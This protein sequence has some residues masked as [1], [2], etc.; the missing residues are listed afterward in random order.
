MDPHQVLGVPPG[1]GRESIDAA[2]Q[3]AIAKLG[4][5]ED[6]WVR[7]AIDA[8]YGE[9][10]DEPI[11]RVARPTSL[12]FFHRQLPLQNETTY[13]ILVNVL[14]LFMT[15]L[16]LAVQG[17]EANPIAAFFLDRWGFP[18]MIAYKMVIVAVVCTISQVVAQR[19]MR[20][21]RGLLW[22]GIIVVGL[23]VLYSVRLL[24]GQFV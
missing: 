13:F 16:V 18:G 8:A 4:S 15:Y 6:N 1:A 7:A 23:V 14:D 19:N 10:C 3:R 21:A 17:I 12:D 9:L 22:L 5:G 2:Y 24:A 11:T 20:Y